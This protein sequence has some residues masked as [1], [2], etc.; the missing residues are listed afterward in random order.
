M[1][2]GKKNKK[3]KKKQKGNGETLPEPTPSEAQTSHPPTIV[4]GSDEEIGEDVVD[5]TTGE[6]W[7][8]RVEMAR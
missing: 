6:E 2:G 4:D 1:D 8:A 3:R 5:V 7:V